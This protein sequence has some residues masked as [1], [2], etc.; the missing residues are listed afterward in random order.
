MYVG[1]WEGAG[2][3]FAWRGVR[4]WVLRRNNQGRGDKGY[5]FKWGDPR[6]IWHVMPFCPHDFTRMENEAM[7]IGG[8]VGGAY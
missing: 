4:V 3:G 5:G 6:F 1:W 2:G 7:A 8:A